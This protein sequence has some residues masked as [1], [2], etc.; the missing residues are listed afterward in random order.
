[1][2]ETQTA[3]DGG[4]TPNERAYIRGELD[5]FFSTLPSVAEG[6]QLKTWRGGPERGK[7]KISPVARGLVER[8]LMRLDT[9]Q[10]LPR[11]VF[12]ESGLA[13]LRTKMSD[14]RLADPKNFAHV[15]QELGIDPHV[16]ADA[17]AAGSPACPGRSPS[18]GASRLLEADFESVDLLPHA[19]EDG[20]DPDRHI[21]VD[22]LV[23]RIMEESPL[24][25]KR[26]GA[27]LAGLA[28]S[29]AKA[30][31][32]ARN[33]RLGGRPKSKPKTVEHHG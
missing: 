29:P 2:T 27:R 9:S 5:L 19:L 10:H 16:P 1:M 17:T 4:F 14:R 20:Q 21:G 25:I 8:G 15:R 23:T 3:P 32:S 30:T 13:A 28:T 18:A 7:P 22:G 6:F 24:A 31:S 26:S 12:T 11:L 33:G